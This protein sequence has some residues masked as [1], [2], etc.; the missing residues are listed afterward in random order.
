[1]SAPPSATRPN[2]TADPSIWRI[3]PGRSAIKASVRSSPCERLTATI[4][5]APG[6]GWARVWIPPAPGPAAPPSRAAADQPAPY[7]SERRRA[8]DAEQRCPV[9]HQREIDRKL[10][11]PGD[12][13]LGSVE[14]IDHKQA[15]AIR[16]FRQMNALLGQR[17][18]VRRDPRQAFG[19]DPVGGEIRLGHRRAVE[20]AVATP[21]PAADRKQDGG[22][23]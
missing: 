20:L 3:A 17:G 7:Q 23:A 22:A 18:D 1:M 16:R 13:F 11:A 9:G 4:Q 12:K 21:P 8:D 5:G 19:N 6:C 2:L 15:A 10:A 14:R